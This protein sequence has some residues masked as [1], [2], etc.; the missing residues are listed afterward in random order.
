MKTW[1]YSKLLDMVIKHY[2]LYHLMFIL[3]KEYPHNK[4]V[5]LER[6]TKAYCPGI[7]IQGSRKAKA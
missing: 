2:K 4:R 5:L 1:F 7:H 3:M 6:L